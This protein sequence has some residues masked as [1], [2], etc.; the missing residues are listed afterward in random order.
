MEDLK[1]RLIVAAVKVKEAEN[2]LAAARTSFDVLFAAATGNPIPATTAGD[3]RCDL[4]IVKDAPPDVPVNETHPTVRKSLTGRGY[5]RGERP[6]PNRVLGGKLRGSLHPKFTPKLEEKAPP[7][8]AD[9]DPSP[10][11][12]FGKILA[13][14]RAH[15]E[16]SFRARDVAEAI[17]DRN[18]Y[19]VGCSLSALR[20]RGHLVKISFGQYALKGGVAGFG[21]KEA[22]GEVREGVAESAAY[23][24][25]LDAFN[26]NAD[27]A[28][29]QIRN[30]YRGKNERLAKAW[31]T[32]WDA[33]GGGSTQRPGRP[34]A[35]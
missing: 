7:P 19:Q 10:D 25:G 9:G 13:H 35:A 24:Q 32:G 2:A 21:E 1:E 29:R 15:P 26:P 20:K 6:K 3:G 16:E 4:L 5:K 31:E 27:L 34:L 11:S 30:P 23:Q 33:G 12:R 18:R 28:T 22:I 17:G 14:F 8:P